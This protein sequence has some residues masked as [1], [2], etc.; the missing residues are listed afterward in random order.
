[1]DEEAT[2]PEPADTQSSAAASEGPE[3]PAEG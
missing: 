3:A 1:L 2:T